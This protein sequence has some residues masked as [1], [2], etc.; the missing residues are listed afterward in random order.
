MTREEAAGRL[1]VEAER[2]RQ[3]EETGLL[4]SLPRREGAVDYR[5]EDAH[6]LCLI[7]TLLETGMETAALRRYLEL[8]A[9]GA[10]TAEEQVRILKQQ[11]FRLLEDIH[12]RQ[13]TLDCLD[14]II[15]QV[16]KGGQAR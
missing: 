4:D 15:R 10:D 13:K 2:L 5:E 14:Y 3:Y 8:A 16:E 11:R 1:G 9:S 12:A 6:L 7:H